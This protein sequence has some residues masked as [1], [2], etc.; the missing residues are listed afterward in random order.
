ML[1][2]VRTIEVKAYRDAAGD[3]TC[4]KR[5]AGARCLFLR[6]RKFGAIGVCA[7]TGEDLLRGPHGIQPGEFAADAES[8][9]LRPHADC[10]LWVQKEV[11]G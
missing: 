8:H 6:T 5:W 7:V 3:P 4:C 2:E 9:L 11:K 1:V 10:P